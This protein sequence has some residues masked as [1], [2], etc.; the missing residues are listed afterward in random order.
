MLLV[1]IPVMMAMFHKFRELKWYGLFAFACL[2]MFCLAPGIF[3]RVD[4]LTVDFGKRFSIWETAVAGI[5]EH[6]LFGQGA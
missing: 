3:P 1:A 2:V 4:E 6:P 5:R